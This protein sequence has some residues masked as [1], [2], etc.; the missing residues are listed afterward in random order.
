M[1]NP[2]RDKN[3]GTCVPGGRRDS[4][5]HGLSSKIAQGKTSWRV[6]VTLE[7]NEIAVIVGH[8]NRGVSREGTVNFLIVSW[9]GFFFL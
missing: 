4:C 9:L 8:G 7:K 2:M 1:L 6:K 3:E 5:D